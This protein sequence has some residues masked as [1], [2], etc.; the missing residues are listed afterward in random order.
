MIRQES[1]VA[2]YW[3]RRLPKKSIPIAG[4]LIFFLLAI[5]TAVAQAPTADEGMHLLRGQVL[6]QTGQLV[7]QGEHIPLSHRLIGL[8]LTIEPTLPDASQLLSRPIYH[9]SNWYKSS[10]G[11]AIPLSLGPCLLAACPSFLL[12]YCLGLFS[13]GG[14]S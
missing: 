12:A 5:Q 14:Q 11:E 4:L 2:K 7:L 8:F 10:F 9:Q 6:R 3:R 1:G 13:P